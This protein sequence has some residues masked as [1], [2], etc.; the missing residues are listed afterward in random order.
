MNKQMEYMA[1]GKPVDAYSLKETMVTGGDVCQYVDGD[2]P[3]GLAEQVHRHAADAK[4]RAKLGKAGLK[5]VQ[6]VLSW[7][8]QAPYLLQIYEELFPGQIEWGTYSAS[9]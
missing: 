9:A 3:R 8:H 2:D 1:L 7:P 5:R 6:D 4:L